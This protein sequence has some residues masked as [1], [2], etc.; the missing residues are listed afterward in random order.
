MGNH[1]CMVRRHELSDLEWE[2]LSGL[3]PRSSSGRPRSD[4]RRVLNGIV[5]K[6]RTGSAWRDVPERYGPWR[7]VYTRFRR[8]ALDGTFT[9]ILVA[10][11][12]R[13][14]AAGDIY[15]L[16]SVHSTV[17]RAH[18]ADGARGRRQGRGAKYVVTPSQ[19]SRGTPP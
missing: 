19:A 3:L 4:D 8:W 16:V 17:A 12:A 7:T 1:V 15:W 5:W 6:L 2:A 13:K 9:R 14:S 18:L 10:I 11:Q